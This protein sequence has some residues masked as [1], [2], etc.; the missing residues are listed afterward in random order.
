MIAFAPRLFRRF[1]AKEPAWIETT[2]LQ[3]R[4]STGGPVM[5]IDVRQPEEFTD[6]PGHLPGAVNVPLAELA[7]HTPDLVARRQPLV[8]VCKTDRRSA[9]AATELLAAG[10]DDVTVLHGGTDAWHRQGFAL[11]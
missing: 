6:P 2:E 4:L 5:I 9:R 8:V 3:Q 1:H 11:E 7:Q 10:L